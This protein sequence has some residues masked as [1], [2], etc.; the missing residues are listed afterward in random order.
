MSPPTSRT[1][2][3]ALVVL[4]MATALFLMAGAPTPPPLPELNEKV[5][6]FARANLGKPVGDGSCIT[7][8]FEALKEAGA[9][10]DP[11]DEP[12][13]D[14]TWGQ[15]VASFKEALPGDIL[16]FHNAVFRGR[17]TLSRGRWMTWRE[18]YPHH[19]AIVSQVDETGK[20]VTILHQNV[21]MQG[22]AGKDSKNVREGT[23]RIDSLQKGGWI[24]IYRPVPASTPRR[25]PAIP[26]PITDTDTG[27]DEG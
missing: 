1:R 26:A 6:A 21:I 2:P 19:T 17:Q 12:G 24:R 3:R 14:F 7:L 4:S 22:K 5:V 16:Q 9:Q 15:P 13:G 11:F 23:L 8:A 27:T 25:G 20:L 10:F 18:E